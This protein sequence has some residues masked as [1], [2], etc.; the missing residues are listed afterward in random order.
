MRAAEFGDGMTAQPTCIGDPLYGIC[1]LVP[2]R[3]RLHAPGLVGHRVIVGQ[4]R[5]NASAT[6]VHCQ[7]MRGLIRAHQVSRRREEIS[8]WNLAQIE[9]SAQFGFPASSAHSHDSMVLCVSK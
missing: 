8:R 1:G 4:L 6:N 2:Q 9:Y 5:E 3:L 7:I